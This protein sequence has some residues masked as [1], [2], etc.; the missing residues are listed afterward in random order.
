[1][2]IV[3]SGTVYVGPGGL[4]PVVSSGTATGCASTVI[5]C[6]TMI[7]TTGKFTGTA[8]ITGCK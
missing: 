6:G 7:A 5:G 1:M 4:I 3:G 8:I 2:N